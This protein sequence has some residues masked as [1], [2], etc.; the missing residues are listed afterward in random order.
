MLGEMNTRAKAESIHKQLYLSDGRFQ[1]T[2]SLLESPFYTVF[3]AKMSAQI[4]QDAQL[5][6]CSFPEFVFFIDAAACAKVVLSMLN[7]HFA[8]I[9]NE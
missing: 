6:P 3:E 5:E 8:C 9:R 4:C 7:V 2:F 1:L